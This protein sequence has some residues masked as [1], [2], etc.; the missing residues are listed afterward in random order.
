MFDELGRR[1]TNFDIIRHYGKP[2]EGMIPHSGRYEYG[3]GEN[4]FQRDDENF[5][6]PEM[7]ITRYLQQLK[8]KG[9]TKEAEQVKALKEYLNDPKFSPDELDRIKAVEK[10][11][12]NAARIT[13]AVR[14]KEH[15]YSTDTIAEKLGTTKATVEG[16][17][18]PEKQRAYT[19]LITR[20]EFLKDAVDTSGKPIDI[21]AGVG[22]YLGC[23]DDD[24][25]KSVKY[26]EEQ[27]YRK[28]KVGIDQLSTGNTTSGL[29]LIPPPSEGQTLQEKYK[30]AKEQIKNSDYDIPGCNIDL[31]AKGNIVVNKLSTPV[32]VDPSR[33]Q[34]NYGTEKIGKDG[35]TIKGGGAL[36]DGVIELRRGVPDLDM[37]GKNY[38][39]VRI[40]VNGDNYLKG[41][42]VYADDLPDGI[43]IRFNTN[44]KEGT[45]MLS[46]DTEKGVLK[47]IKEAKIDTGDPTQMLGSYITRQNSYIDE[48]GNK[49]I[50]ALNIIREQDG[51]LDLNGE[52]ISAWSDYSNTLASQ[53]LAKQNPQLAEKQL[54]KTIKQKEEQL[55]EIESLTNP[56]IKQHYLQD[57][58]DECT[59]DSVT[60]K[61]AAI[62][63][64]SWNVIL[65]ITSLKD[66]EIYAPNYKNGERVA[67]VRYPHAGTFEIPDLIV[68]NNNR[69]GKKVIG[70]KDSNGNLV[71]DA[72]G[73][74]AKVAEKLSGADF[75][76]DTVIVIPNNNGQIKTRGTLK[77]MKDYD[78]GYYGRD[79]VV[80]PGMKILK[81]Q[82]KQTEM[83]KVSNLIMDM[84][85]LGADDGEIA[86][87]TKH[88]MVV[89]DAEK[90]KYNYR[91][92]AKDNDIESLKKKYQIKTDDEGN[93][94]IDPKTGKQAYGGAATIF[95]RAKGEIRVPEK[96]AYAKIDDDGYQ[97]VLKDKNLPDTKKNRDY[98][99]FTGKTLNV[100][101][102]KHLD[103]TEADWPPKDINLN[104]TYKNGNKKYTVTESVNKKGQKKFRVYYK[105]FEY[106][107]DGS[108]KQKTKMVKITRMEATDDARTLIS[109]YNTKIEQVY[110]D[111]ANKLKQ[112]SRKA[113]VEARD[114]ESYKISKSAAEIYKDE[115]N[116]LKNKLK[117]AQQYRPLERKAQSVA[118]QIYKQDKE[119]ADEEYDTSD[120]KRAKAIATAKARTIVG[121]SA[122]DAGKLKSSKR[123]TLTDNEWEAI[124][125]HAVSVNLLKEI[126]KN[127]DKDSLRKRSMPRANNDLSEAQKNKILA[128]VNNG[129]TQAEIAQALGI[130]TSTVSRVVNG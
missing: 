43:D 9:I 82:A 55:K 96:R 5:E 20:A 23:S 13:Y 11:K 128:L 8:V 78:P 102:D 41:M 85:T 99:M 130:S 104:E 89:I 107:E 1:I 93:A 70:T 109:A 120:E 4:G 48:K 117:E 67:L 7:K 42:A 6:E 97:Y 36:K 31:D 112:M 25:Q 26:L 49:K 56:V 106:N 10:A 84:T 50:G 113:L 81:G 86:R 54:T 53:F 51:G 110:A 71:N 100:V 24:L 33:I 73:I 44:K 65:P 57:F 127:T 119:N 35:E 40:L 87:A 68:N 22:S 126:V 28:I 77:E 115:V 15:G 74:N 75:D 30:E 79:D 76:G 92:S 90:H 60:L 101:K 59:T 125:S 69:E 52:K 27:G 80:Y 47:Q 123:I 62:S 29:F 122:K 21:G 58:A 19:A 61:A 91:Q 83:G 124:Q 94:I 38:A 129:Y 88:S 103:Y 105:D 18:E 37:G 32:S 2:H 114:V 116:S 66:N 45:P 64:Q 98:D 39:Q 63:R 17:L 95:T 34:I 72:V 14:L 12:L 46:S 111:Y 118:S 108:I 3:S 121:A 16:Y